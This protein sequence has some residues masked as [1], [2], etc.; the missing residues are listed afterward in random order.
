[1]DRFLLVVLIL[2]IVAILIYEIRKGQFPFT[3]VDPP[4][5]SK[6]L[7][8]RWDDLLPPEPQ[9]ELGIDQSAPQLPG[10]P[11]VPPEILEFLLSVKRRTSLEAPD[12][13]MLHQVLRSGILE[14]ETAAFDILR[15]FPEEHQF[16]KDFIKEQERLLRE[17][18]QTAS[19][20]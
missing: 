12:R 11:G 17:K 2:D 4:T 3:R 10:Q 6:N 1:M 19:R 14:A 9:S 7:K 20:K 18:M 5:E 16:L 13:E 15:R 8:K